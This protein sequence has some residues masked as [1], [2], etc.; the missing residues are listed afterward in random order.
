MSVCSRTPATNC[1]DLGMAGY[2][3]RWNSRWPGSSG[4]RDRPL[5]T[6]FVENGPRRTS[7]SAFQIFQALPDALP[8]DRPRGV[9]EKMLVGLG[10]LHHG[11]GLAVDC[12]SDRAACRTEMSHHLRRV[13]AEQRHRLGVL[14]LSMRSAVKVTLL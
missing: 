13:I 6:K 14:V 7:A 5:I 12:Q 8:S 11:G 10:I 2:R 3:C 1:G 4:Q 9:V